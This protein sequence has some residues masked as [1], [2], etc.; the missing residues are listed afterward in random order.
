[1]SFG[2]TPR[3]L[4]PH[5]DFSSMREPAGLEMAKLLSSLL[6]RAVGISVAAAALILIVA[7]AFS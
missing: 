6:V 1:M 2:V 3:A 5:Q 4:T 7:L